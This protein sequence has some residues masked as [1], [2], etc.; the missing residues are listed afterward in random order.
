MKGTLLFFNVS[1]VLLISAIFSVFGCAGAKQEAALQTKPETPAPAFEIFSLPLPA[2][3]AMQD[4]LGVATDPF[5]LT[6]VKTRLLVIEAFSMY[7][8]HCQR[9][10]PLI[11]RFHGMIQS[12]GLEKQIKIIGIGVGNTRFEV[13]TFKKKFQVSFPLFPDEDLSLGRRMGVKRTPTFLAI[14]I[15]EDGSHSHVMFRPGRIKSPSSF[16]AD[17]QRLA[18]P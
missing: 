3:K 13:E 18:G 6:A 12:R 4:Y 7:C 14:R 10:A 5:P 17:L 16:L 11:N 8:P 9:E 2:D 15:D 1:M